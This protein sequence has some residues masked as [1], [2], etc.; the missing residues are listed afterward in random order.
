MKTTKKKK[1]KTKLPALGF[2]PTSRF[3]GK[4]VGAKAPKS[5]F[6]RTIYK[7]QHKG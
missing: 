4:Q 3:G 2:K 7:T 1:T 5:A 6:K